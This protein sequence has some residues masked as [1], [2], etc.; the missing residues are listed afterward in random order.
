MTNGLLRGDDPLAVLG[1]HAGG[2]QPN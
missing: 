2:T 1:K